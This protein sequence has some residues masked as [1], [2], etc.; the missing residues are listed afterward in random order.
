MKLSLSRFLA[1]VPFA[2]RFSA[3][4]ILALVFSFG[5][6]ASAN[7]VSAQKK[8]S[9]GEILGAVAAIG[10]AAIEYHQ[11]LESIE[12]RAMDHVL[13]Q[14]PAIESFEL[15]IMNLNG[16]K[17]SDV[18]SS[19]VIVFSLRDFRKNERYVLLM[20]T[21]SGWVNNF[22]LDIDLVKWKLLQIDEWN[23][24]FLS[25]VDVSVAE[26]VDVDFLNQSVPRCEH[27]GYVGSYMP[28]P[29]DSTLLLSGRNYF[30]LPGPD[31]EQLPV[32]QLGFGRDGLWFVYNDEK[33]RKKS[34]QVVP[35]VG[36]SDDQ[37]LVQTFSEEIRMIVNEN[38]M[39]LF[40]NDL[41]RSIQLTRRVV[42]DIHGFL[43]RTEV[44]DFGWN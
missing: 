14:Y 44:D 8:N 35:F 38:A 6:S 31:A 5:L 34:D 11:L 12:L 7:T 24:L 17:I 30:R 27:L 39:G 28:A 23:E 16:K 40:F 42:R 13:S 18:S 29:Y 36:L 41:N 22:G 3:N 1:L 37:Y 2:V 19:D 26:G 10:A 15:K 9:N 20:V 32:S 4:L 33:G 25:F 43:N 21:S